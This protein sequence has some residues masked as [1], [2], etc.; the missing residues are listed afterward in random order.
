MRLFFSSLRAERVNTCCQYVATTS[1]FPRLLSVTELRETRVGL[2]LILPPFTEVCY[3]VYTI[4]NFTS[5]KLKQ[6]QGK[7]LS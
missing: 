2:L 3:C 6:N 4:K 5:V 1:A 7:H